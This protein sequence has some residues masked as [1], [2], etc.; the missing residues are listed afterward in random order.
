M[1]G[2]I[3]LNQSLAERSF[4][5]GNTISE[6][7]V[8]VFNSFTSAPEFPHLMRWF[9]HLKSMTAEELSA[10]T[11]ADEDDD[12][13]LF[14]DDD[15]EE[16]TRAM[17]A[18]KKKE[19]EEKKAAAKPLGK[20]AVI[21]EVKPWGEDTNLIALESKIRN[22]QMEGLEWQI[23]KFVDIAY[24]VKKNTNYLRCG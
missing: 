10:T 21:Y 19:E 11:A 5:N 17:L 18:K 14:G 24:G 2:L 23:A 13:D 12:I 16:E 15:D 22:I 8:K 20:T 1:E 3:S 9:R 7:D 6:E 4:I